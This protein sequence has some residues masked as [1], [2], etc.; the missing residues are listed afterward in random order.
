MARRVH[1]VRIKGPKVD[2]TI[3]IE[4]EAPPAIFRWIEDAAHEKAMK[5]A[6]PDATFTRSVTD[7][8]EVQK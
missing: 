2:L 1:A 4:G 6:G 8:D 3:T 7:L 5:L